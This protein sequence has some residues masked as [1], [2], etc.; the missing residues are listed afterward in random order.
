MSQGLLLCLFCVTVSPSLRF[1]YL[2]DQMSFFLPAYVMYAP[3]QKN[4]IFTR[5]LNYF[6]LCT[7]V[8]LILP[9]F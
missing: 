6:V 4:L 9:Q 3:V 5:F 8:F 2:Y 7:H 1:S